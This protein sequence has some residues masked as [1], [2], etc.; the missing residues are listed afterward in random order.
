MPFSRTVCNV[1]NARKLQNV[2]R[3]FNLEQGILKGN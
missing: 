2:I 3:D 1:T